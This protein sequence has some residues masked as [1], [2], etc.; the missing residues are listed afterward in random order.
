MESIE[1]LEGEYS[2]EVGRFLAE[3]A[4]GHDPFQL[5]HFI[6]DMYGLTDYGHYRQACREVSARWESMKGSAQQYDKAAAYHD[7][8]AHKAKKI[9]ENPGKDPEEAELKARVMDQMVRQHKINMDNAARQFDRQHKEFRYFLGEAR[10]WEK[11]IEGK[12]RAKLIQ[13]FWVAKVQ[14]MITLGTI[15][16][17]GGTDAVVEM[18]LSMPEELHAPLL[19]GLEEMKFRAKVNEIQLQGAAIKALEQPHNIL[20]LNGKK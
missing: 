17:G 2:S 6:M 19:N 18:V 13:D 9:R 20:T 4:D 16:G 5:K 12:D 1:K 10:R 15:G 14:R 11:E 7:L 8:Y 3:T